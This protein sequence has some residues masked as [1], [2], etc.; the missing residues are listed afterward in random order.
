MNELK[1]FENSEFGKVRVQQKDDNIF[2]CLKDVCDILEIVNVSQL[3]T[4]LKEDGVITNEVGVQTGIKKDGTPAMQNIEMSFINESNLY[5]V[6][7]QSRKENAEQFTEWVTSE[8]LPSIRKHGA[9][10]T[11]AKI[12]EVL[13]NPDTIIRLAMNLKEEKVKRLL[14]E[15][16]IEEDKG[17]VLFAEAVEAT[18]D[19]ILIGELAKI[20]RQKG[21]DIGQNRLFEKLRDLGYLGSKGEYKNIPTQKSMDLEI[22][23][24][25][26][27]EVLHSDGSPRIVTTSFVNAKGI[28]YFVNKFLN[29]KGLLSIK[30][31]I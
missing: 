9:Y 18:K 14:L 16:K 29:A 25:V 3:K 4:R 12:E 19:C 30:A 13:S 10:L 11:E 23:K 27:R 24:I 5:K 26:K 7:F 22:F 28:L 21:I 6:I 1:I 15:N 20:L 17:K 8:V 31:V 2:F